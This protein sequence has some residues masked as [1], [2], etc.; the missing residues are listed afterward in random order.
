MSLKMYHLSAGSCTKLKDLCKPTDPQ[1]F[2]S[3]YDCITAL[4]WRCMTRARVPYLKMDIENTE[5]N[6]SHAVDLRG[7]FGDIVPIEYFGDG[8]LMGVTENISVAELIGGPG[9]AKAAQAIRQSILDITVDSMP[10]LLKVREGIEGREEMRW[11]W[12]P[13]NVV[14]TSWTGMQPFTKYDFGYGLPVS[15][16]LSASAFEGT[17]GVLPANR[18]DGKSDGFD[19]YICLENSCHTRLEADPEYRAFC[20]LLG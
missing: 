1:K 16:R 3:T 11:I 5:T 17:L 10:A 9:L 7:R 15:I 8:L 12:H 14:G 6:Y 19:V 13:Q 18:I 2:V 20:S 4:T